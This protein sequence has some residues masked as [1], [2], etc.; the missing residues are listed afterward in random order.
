MVS[1]IQRIIF[2]KPPDAPE[3]RETPLEPNTHR[4][5]Q[6]LD[7]AEL[8]AQALRALASLQQTEAEL[9]EREQAL[10]G[11]A[12][13][14]YEELK[15]AASEL[16]AIREQRALAA[17]RADIIQSAIQTLK[18]HSSHTHDTDLH[19]RVTSDGFVIQPQD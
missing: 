13:S 2:R 9:A 14:L 18:E 8:T 17:E 4:R 1:R 5:R 10:L 12:S 19:Q 6:Q 3:A 16:A 7:S 15:V 11:Q